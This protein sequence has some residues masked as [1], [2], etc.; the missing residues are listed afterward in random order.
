MSDSI[1]EITLGEHT[2]K[3]YQ[4]SDT[5]S[6]REWS[7][8]SKMI[9]LGKY[10]HLGDDHEFKNEDTDNWD[11]FEKLIKRKLNVATIT[12]VYGY[13]HGGLSISTTPYQCRFDSGVLGFAVVTKELIRENWNIKRVTKKYIELA[14][15]MVEGEVETLN[16]Y[17]N[18]EVYS[19]R[20]EDKDGEVIDSCGGF[21]DMD[22]I[23]DHVDEMFVEALKGN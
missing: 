16:K 4:D 23:Q 12:K 9:F 8:V 11:D 2:L 7:N 22:D 14:D 1:K 10:S 20:I 19:F 13:S 15:K 21:Y 3:V 5:E 18:N 6:P 17:I